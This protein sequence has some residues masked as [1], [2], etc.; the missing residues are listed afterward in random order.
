MRT[1]LTLLLRSRLPPAARA[2]VRRLVASGQLEFTN[3]G[4][5]QHDEATSHYSAMIDQMTMGMR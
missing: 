3:G 1:A 4:L 5:V 2:V